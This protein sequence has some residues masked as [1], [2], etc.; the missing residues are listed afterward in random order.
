MISIGLTGYLIFLDS[1]EFVAVSKGRRKALNGTW[2]GTI[3]QLDDIDGNKARGLAELNLHARRKRI[4]GR[5]TIE[6]TVGESSHTTALKLK[7]GFKL[8]R[9]LELNCVNENEE[10]VQFGNLV[11]ELD[12]YGNKMYGRI[13]G[14]GPISRKIVSS[15]LDLEKYT[16]D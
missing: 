8:D 10:I 13:Q 6:M 15:E 11:L 16:G 9:F 7:G 5:I 1:R 14:Y 3:R 12:P 2:K 4:S